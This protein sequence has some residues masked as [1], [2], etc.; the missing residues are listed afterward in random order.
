MVCVSHELVY[1][2]IESPI[3]ASSFYSRRRRSCVV[4]LYPIQYVNGLVL[5]CHWWWPHGIETCLA[6]CFK[7]LKVCVI[8]YGDPILHGTRSFTILSEKLSLFLVICQVLEAESI[9]VTVS[10]TL[11]CFIW[12]L[13]KNLSWRFVWYKVSSKRMDSII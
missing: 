11:F 1:C 3:C 7:V 2:P 9:K 8:L 13:R 10:T 6:L 12:I 4:V 5:I